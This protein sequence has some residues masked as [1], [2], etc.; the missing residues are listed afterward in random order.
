MEGGNG[1]LGWPLGCCIARRQQK[2]Q[3]ELSTGSRCSP[4]TSSGSLAAR[5]RIPAACPRLLYLLFQPI[6]FPE[7]E[8]VSWENP[9]L[10]S[11]GRVRN[12]LEPISLRQPKVLLTSPSST[13]LVPEQPAAP[14]IRHRPQ[15]VSTT[16]KWPT[17]NLPS[18]LPCLL[19]RSRPL[20]MSPTSNWRS[21][22]AS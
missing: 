19:S 20:T 8:L 11:S 5:S 21:A 12:F 14:T 1:T 10:L 6:K 18:F 22:K 9:R 16:P 2:H 7:L 4:S 15:V 17:M 3:E 13:P